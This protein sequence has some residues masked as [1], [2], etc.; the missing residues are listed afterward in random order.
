MS[1]DEEL[2]P[3]QSHG[4][5]VVQKAK[6]KEHPSHQKGTEQWESRKPFRATGVNSRNSTSNKTWT[7]KNFHGLAGSR[8]QLEVGLVSKRSR[9]HGSPNGNLGQFFTG[10]MRIPKPQIAKGHGCFD[11]GTEKQTMDPT[12]MTF[13]RSHAGWMLQARPVS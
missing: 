11:Q 4:Q 1:V 5:T 3:S 2:V 6:G 7:L 12:P 8:L 9:G 13:C 10:S